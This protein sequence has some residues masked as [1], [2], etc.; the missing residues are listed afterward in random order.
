MCFTKNL[1]TLHAIDHQLFD[2]VNGISSTTLHVA[3]HLSI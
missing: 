1:A 3:E 2:R